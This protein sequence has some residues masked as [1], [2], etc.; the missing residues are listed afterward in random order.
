MVLGRRSR[1]REDAEDAENGVTL[2]DGARGGWGKVDLRP[3]LET[4][5]NGRIHDIY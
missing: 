5:K 1:K 3:L 2:K 4:A